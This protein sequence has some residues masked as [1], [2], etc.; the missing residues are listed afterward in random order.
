[1]AWLFHANGVAAVQAMADV[2]TLCLAIPLIR[3]VLR[4]VRSHAVEAGQP[5]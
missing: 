4:E 5:V 1:M 3:K 2:L